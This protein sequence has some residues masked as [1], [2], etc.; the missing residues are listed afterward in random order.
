MSR[1][2]PSFEEYVS[3]KKAV[4]AEV[5]KLIGK[6]QIDAALQKIRTDDV[7][8]APTLISPGHATEKSQFERSLRTSSAVLKPITIPRPHAPVQA[9]SSPSS[10]SP[11]SLA[12]FITQPSPQKL[13]A[14]NVLATTMA[15]QQQ[16]A[17]SG[18]SALVDFA[19]TLLLDL[20]EVGKV[21]SHYEAIQDKKY[22]KTLK[23]LAEVEKNMNKTLES[24]LV[25]ANTMNIDRENDS[26]KRINSISER[27]DEILSS[28]EMTDRDRVWSTDH[29]DRAFDLIEQVAIALHKC[30]SLQA[31]QGIKHVEEETIKQVQKLV[32]SEVATI[33]RDL[34][35]IKKKLDTKFSKLG[36]E[37][38]SFAA[39]YGMTELFDRIHR[40]L[41]QTLGRNMPL[42]EEAQE[43]RTLFKELM[44]RRDRWV[45][46]RT[47][48]LLEL[49]QKDQLLLSRIKE[50]ADAM[51]PS[52]EKQVKKS[53]PRDYNRLDFDALLDDV[54]VC[55]GMEIYFKEIPG[56]LLGT[57]F[58][59]PTGGMSR[60]DNETAAFS[61]DI[62]P[63]QDW[64]R[65]VK[66]F[67]NL[68]RKILKSHGVPEIWGVYNGFY[69]T[70][71]DDLVRYHYDRLLMSPLPIPAELLT[72]AAP[73]STGASGLPSS[74]GEASAEDI[75]GGGE[76]AGLSAAALKD[77]SV[78][79][80]LA[81]LTGETKIRTFKNTL[82]LKFTSAAADGAPKMVSVQV[83]EHWPCA[84]ATITAL[85]TRYAV[86]VG[87][88]CSLINVSYKGL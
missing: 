68:E 44:Q 24:L 59:D 73:S 31:T 12:T 69:A 52:F 18:P 49:Q 14:A 55:S 45:G 64:A 6:S 80:A 23:T 87:G 77:T 9:S 27:L 17:N 16:L 10:S 3:T 81:Q 2:V 88:R 35:T 67:L 4:Y 40:K 1:T 32:T 78:V 21:T 61:K 63:T 29:L 47:E 42:Y 84:C 65:A 66:T 46:R 15:Q 30:I 79:S 8:I 48:A 41:M 71:E 76:T 82:P 86:W 22:V 25:A 72:G 75:E 5:L 56:N 70:G 28:K 43:D 7:V 13:A 26:I 11:V 58:K 19:Y 57:V 50:A 37:R 54:A 39:E 85:C 36:L 33:R 34:D 53:K 60:W 20:W 83:D 51:R 74:S 38:G 62:R